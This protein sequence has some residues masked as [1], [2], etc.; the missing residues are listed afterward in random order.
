MTA[1]RTKH[2]ATKLADGRVLIVGG[3]KTIQDGYGLATAEIYDPSTKQF[4]ATGSLDRPLLDHGAT[5]LSNGQVLIS[6]GQNYTGPVAGS[7]VYTPSAGTFASFLT[8]DIFTTVTPALV[9]LPNSSALLVNGLGPAEQVAYVW[10]SSTHDYGEASYY[11][12]LRERPVAIPVQYTGT[13]L[14][15]SILVAGGVEPQTGSDNGTLIE[16]YSPANNSWSTAGNMTTPREGHSVTLYG[17]IQASTT[18]TLSATPNPA[19]VGTNVTFA[20]MVKSS[21]TQTGTVTFFDGTTSLESKQ[22]YNG[23]AT[24]STTN[25]TAGTHPIT[26]QYNGDANNLQSRSSAVSEV[27]N[28]P[29]LTPVFRT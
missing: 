29:T 27:I 8:T 16:I 3:A 13:A 4:T 14:D 25:L 17:A 15:N 22:L 19:N 11:L 1:A 20:A 2:T 12:E 6:G 24:Y 5:L 7:Y 23:T 9:P 21:G 28:A 26:A 10:N 18:T